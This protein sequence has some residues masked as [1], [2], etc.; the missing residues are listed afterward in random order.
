MEF[1]NNRRIKTLTIRMLLRSRLIKVETNEFINSKRWGNG[2][3]NWQEG[4]GVF[5]YSHSHI[6][7]VIR[8]IMNQELKHKRI[9][10]KEEYHQFLKKFHISFDDKYLFQFFEN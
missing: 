4:Y 5:S 3:F 2:K 7:S 1:E 8:Y 9:N 10:F 6:D